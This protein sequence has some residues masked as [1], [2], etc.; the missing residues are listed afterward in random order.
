ML[1]ENVQRH[2]IHRLSG[3]LADYRFP[4]LLHADA[5]GPS[6]SEEYCSDSNLGSG[7]E[8]L[9]V[10][11]VKSVVAKCKIQTEDMSDIQLEPQFRLP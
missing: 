2:M 3:C 5:F 10:F 1:I 4:T 7:F 8:R 9:Q 11:S 6:A